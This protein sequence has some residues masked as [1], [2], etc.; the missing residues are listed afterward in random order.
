MSARP[1][2]TTRI[3]REREVQRRTG[4]C[5]IT[6]W[7]LERLGDFPKRLRLAQNAVGWKEDEIQSWIDTRP[8]GAKR[9]AEAVHV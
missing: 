4:L 9:T 1:P 7:R 5:R 2:A 8:R 3:L 6:I